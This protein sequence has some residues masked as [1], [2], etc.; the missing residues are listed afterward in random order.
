MLDRNVTLLKLLFNN[1]ELLGIREGVLA[2]DH[3]L[4]IRPESGALI[5][6]HFDLDFCFVRASV[7][8]VSFE[9]LNFI[10]SLLQFKVLISHPSLQINDKVVRARLVSQCS[11]W[12][13]ALLL[14]LLLKEIVNHLVLACKLVLGHLKPRS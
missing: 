7:L 5:H 10:V 4:E 3:F 2:L 1:F 8:D 13:L 6:V 12:S 14:L 9:K 11:T